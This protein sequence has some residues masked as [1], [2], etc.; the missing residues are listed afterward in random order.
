VRNYY[1]FSEL[2]DYDVECGNGGGSKLTRANNAETCKRRSRDSGKYR[3]EK[4][5]RFFGEFYGITEGDRVR[6]TDAGW[7]C[8]QRRVGRALGYLNVRYG[9]GA[10]DAAETIH[11]PDYLIV[12]DDD[13]YVDLVDVV[14]YLEKR[15]V[16]HQDATVMAGCLFPEN[17]V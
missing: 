1:G 7:V 12:V 14:T 4:M 9:G 8:A 3:N 15:Q 11:I 5:N 13:S 10:A 17:A 2:Q 16:H 6:S